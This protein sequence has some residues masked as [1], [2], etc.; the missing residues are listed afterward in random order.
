MPLFTNATK[1]FSRHCPICLLP[2]ELKC[3][4][5][6][7]KVVKLRH[8]QSYIIT[9]PIRAL[10]INSF[11]RSGHRKTYITKKGKVYQQAIK[12]ALENNPVYE[13]MTGRIEITIF[14]NLKG[15]R[16]FDGANSEKPLTDCFQGLIFDNDKQI[17]RTIIMRNYDAPKDTITI[18]LNEFR[19]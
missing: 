11:I 17:D 14:V 10:S 1:P 4:K 13:K 8:Y 5:C 3:K 7:Q 19:Y 9:I 15:Y 2:L 6:K 12:E 18:L 16:E